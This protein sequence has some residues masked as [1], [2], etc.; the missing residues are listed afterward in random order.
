MDFN[1]RAVTELLGNPLRNITDNLILAVLVVTVYCKVKLDEPFTVRK[2]T[3]T[4]FMHYKVLVNFIY[5]AAYNPVKLH[6][7]L[8]VSPNRVKVENH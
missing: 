3:N 8:I 6:N 7:L 1:L 4:Q 2:R 5:Y